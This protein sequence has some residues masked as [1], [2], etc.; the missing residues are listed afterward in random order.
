[1]KNRQKKSSARLPGLPVLRALVLVL[2][3]VLLLAAC[4]PKSGALLPG[5][6][7]GAGDGSGGENPEAPRARRTIPYAEMEYQRP[8]TET[9]K[10]RT[11]ELAALLPK[12]PNYAAVQEMDAEVTGLVE[13]F[14]TQYHLAT[15]AASHDVTDS[16]YQEETVWLAE[17]AVALDQL[18]TEFNRGLVEG[19]F[20]G[21]FRAE[22]GS[23]YFEQL[24][25]STAFTSPEVEAWQKEHST[26]YREYEKMI[27]T[28]T[29]NDSAGE[30]YTLEEVQ[31]VA[32]IF[33]Y[34]ELMFEYM[35][36]YLEDYVALYARMIELD[37]LTAQQL[38]FADPATM[39]YLRY[40]RDYSPADAKAMFAQVKEKLVPL[41]PLLQRYD[42][43]GIPYRK[44]LS[45]TGEALRSMDP[46]FAEAWDFMLEYGLYDM[47]GG[48]N[49]RPY[50]AFCGELPA[51][52]A[53]F[54]FQ[55]YDDSF[56]AVN[57]I[58]HEFGHFY[59]YWL[60]YDTTVIFNLDIDE[61][62][63]Q[64]L[65]MLMLP[66]HGRFTEKPELTQA[67]VLA[68]MMM[69]SI[70]YQSALE[71]FQLLA[72]ELEEVNA[73]TLG[74]LY[75]QMM[76]GYGFGAAYENDENGTPVSW[77]FVPHFFDDP[78]YTASYVT[79]AAAALQLWVQS[80]NDWDAALETYQALIHANQNQPFTALLESAG[81]RSPMDAGV[82]DEI[83]RLFVENLSG[84]EKDLPEA[85]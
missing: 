62:Y 81:L 51:Y 76:E 9:M 59:D 21:D 53:P 34:N 58:F 72:Y 42:I 25:L 24:R 57:T 43:E 83:A 49:K 48:E 85:A 60:R 11:A 45:A 16:F 52:D 22:L 35:R 13:A 80:Q 8:D 26:L 20:A 14:K 5:A 55:N 54:L 68:G 56:W 70:L 33:E 19:P 38:G 27:S 63:S 46:E 28:L 36:N 73:V 41:M 69:N 82:I 6:P 75:A 30:A 44:A 32:N 4:T 79:S 66:Q 31:A 67:E 1:M 40:G 71:G 65:E 84:G 29:V 15:L 77:I 2:C 3:A 74:Q 17:E 78:F 39:Y 61:T 12:A 37:K 50:V 23:Y 64:G 18:V 10:A 47:E 7:G